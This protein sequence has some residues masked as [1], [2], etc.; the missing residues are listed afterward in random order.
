MPALVVTALGYIGVT[1]TIA[2]VAANVAVLAASAAV[3]MGLSSYQ[4]RQAKKKARKAYQAPTTSVK[5]GSEPRR[6]SLGRVGKLGGYL[7]FAENINEDVILILVFNQGTITAFDEIYIGDRQVLLAEDGQVTTPPFWHGGNG[8]NNVRSYARIEPHRGYASQ[9]ASPFMLASFPQWTTAHR[10]DGCAY[11]VVHFGAVAQE[12]FQDVFGGT[13]PEVTTVMRTAPVYDPREPSHDPD[14]PDTWEYSDNAA[15]LI[16]DYFTHPDGHGVARAAIDEASFIT[17][18]N[19]CDEFVPLKSGGVERRFRASATYSFDEQPAEVL[20]RLADTCG[21]EFFLTPE[22]KIGIRVAQPMAPTVTITDDDIVSLDIERGNGLLKQYNT[23]VPRYVE[24]ALGWQ[25]V[26][27]AAQSDSDAVLELGR[28]VKEQ[29]DLYYVTSHT[30]AQRLARRELYLNNPRYTGQMVCHASATRLRGHHEFRL[31]SDVYGLDLVC[32]LTGLTEADGSPVVTVTFEAPDPAID[33]WDPDT[34]EGDAPP[35]PDS[36]SDDPTM[37]EAPDSIAFSYET[38]GGVTSAGVR[39]HARERTGQGFT[40]RWRLLGDEEWTTA[41]SSVQGIVLSP[42]TA[43]EDYEFSVRVQTVQG[44]ISA[45]AD[46]QF[47][48]A[49]TA[50]PSLTAPAITLAEGLV[51][52]TRVTLTQSASAGAWAIQWIATPVLGSVSWASP[53]TVYAAPGA[54]VID[55]LTLTPG[56]YTIRARAVSLA[57]GT[58]SAAT[59]PTSVTVLEPSATTGGGGSQGDGVAGGGAGS[60][61]TGGATGGAGTSSDPG[62]ASGSGLW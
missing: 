25:F 12:R 6:R 29:T 60:G 5:G 27:A 44:G 34:H 49:E 57:G 8:T 23:V 56:D 55:T 37:P 2:T 39:W 24:P 32:R 4:Q 22:G 14:D 40:V 19:I 15:L 51:N 3:N 33:A 20:D 28:Q 35:I 59:G 17:A 16:L 31:K 53:R 62:N 1:G 47:T 21:A 48:P 30:Q 38:N 7:A 36:T 54:Q 42:V 61:T 41:T 45:W 26:D 10:L 11:L 9:P 52:Q 50:P 46:A 18:A 58:I 43:G 13:I